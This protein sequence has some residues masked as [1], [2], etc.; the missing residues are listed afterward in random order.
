MT[1]LHNK[2]GASKAIVKQS[3]AVRCTRMDLDS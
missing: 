1:K 3:P 2:A